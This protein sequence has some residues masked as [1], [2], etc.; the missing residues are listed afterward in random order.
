MGNTTGSRKKKAIRGAWKLG[1]VLA[2]NTLYALGVTLFL[3]PSGLITGG[4]TGLGLVAEHF[5]HVPQMCIRDSW[6]AW[7]LCCGPV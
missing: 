5:F 2:G 6:R 1:M 3:L 4:T 7:E